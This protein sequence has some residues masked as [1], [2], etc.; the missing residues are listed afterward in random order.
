[1]LTPKFLQSMCV[2][3]VTQGWLS[4]DGPGAT[5]PSGPHSGKTSLATDTLSPRC[6]LGRAVVDSDPASQDGTLHR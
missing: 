2:P 3:A 5:A 6:R 1:M 4:N